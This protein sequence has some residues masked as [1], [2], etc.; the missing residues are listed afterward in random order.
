MEFN[1]VIFCGEGHNLVPLTSPGESRI[2]KALLPVANKPLIEYVLEWCDQAPFQ[3][4]NIVTEMRDEKQI[5]EVVAQ[6]EKHRDAEL[7]NTSP[8]RI[9]TSA[10]KSTGAIL[11]EIFPVEEGDKSH[12]NYVVLPCDFITDVPPQVFIE[13][14]RGNSDENIGLSLFYNNI[15]EAV[16]KKVLRSNYTVYSN[17]ENGNMVLLDMYS[18]DFVT[19]DK[20]LKIRS[21]LL[22]RYPSTLVSTTLL[23]S[24]IFFMSGRCRQHSVSDI[25]PHRPINKIKRDLARNSWQ[26]SD[27]KS[28]IGLFALP[29][30]AL[31]VR[32]NNL[33]VYMEMNRYFLR[34]VARFNPNKHN[35]A[36]KEN[37]D[38]ATVGSDCIVGHDSVLGERTNVKRSVIGHNV[39]IGRRCRISGCI[40]LDGVTLDDEVQLENCIVG[41]NVRMEHRARLVNCNVE[42]SYTVGKNVNLKGETLKNISLDE[43]SDGVLYESESDDTDPASSVV[44]GSDS[45]SF[46]DEGFEEEE[47]DDDIF[48]R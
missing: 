39:H 46:D 29:Q 44:A 3:T 8:I 31:F 18:K 16:D 15:F 9:F 38:S 33:P 2:S 34:D 42:G 28:T 41:K 25:Q 14:Y 47:Y 1:A 5:G 43:L 40:L 26:H 11:S 27:S 7:R 32:C 35:N 6:Y 37:K 24:F 45:E 17:Q 13:V 19:V 36:N 22:W 48:T 23:D 4:V 12:E 30:N 20:F 21:Q 10:L